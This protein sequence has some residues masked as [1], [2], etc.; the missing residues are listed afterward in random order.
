MSGRACV[1]VRVRVRVRACARARTRV[2]LCMFARARG[3]VHEHALRV[4]CVNVCVYVELHDFQS[5]SVPNAKCRG[6]FSPVI[7]WTL[8]TPEHSTVSVSPTRQNPGTT[9]AS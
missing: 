1:R 4:L 9:F 2:C 6:H 7:L 8:Q 3:C 5:R